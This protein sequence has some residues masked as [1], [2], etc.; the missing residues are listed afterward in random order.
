MHECFGMY[1]VSLIEK[2][3]ERMCFNAIKALL[4]RSNYILL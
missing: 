2:I 4:L 1:F 3:E